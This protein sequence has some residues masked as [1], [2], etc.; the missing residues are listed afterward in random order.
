MEDQSGEKC[1]FTHITGWLNVG[2]G[3]AGEG[4]CKGKAT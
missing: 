2:V 4:E 1:T 3:W